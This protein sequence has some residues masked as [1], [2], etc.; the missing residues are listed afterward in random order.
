MQDR[1]DV[2]LLLEELNFVSKS[3]GIK[4]RE[5]DHVVCNGSL[6]SWRDSIMTAVQKIHECQ[7]IVPFLNIIE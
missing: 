1:R 2:D 7:I 6:E 5:P 3:F 4:V